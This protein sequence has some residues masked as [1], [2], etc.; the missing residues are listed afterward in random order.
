MWGDLGDVL[1]RVERLKIEHPDPDGY[2]YVWNKAIAA[3]CKEIAT[4]AMPTPTAP[5]VWRPF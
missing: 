1:R 3:A 5:P 2:D 4:A